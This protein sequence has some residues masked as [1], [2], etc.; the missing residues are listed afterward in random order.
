[1]DRCFINQPKEKDQLKTLLNK[2]SKASKNSGTGEKPNHQSRINNIQKFIIQNTVDRI[3]EFAVKNNVDVIVFE[4]LGRMKIPKGTFGAKRFRAKLQHWAK[5]KIQ[6]KVAE[7]A[8]SLGIRNSKVIARGTSMYAFD[9]SGK[10][11]RNKKKDIATFST[12]KTYHADLSASYNIGARYFLREIL[13]PFS[14][15]E[16]L[17]HS[18]KVPDVLV[19]TRH[20]LATLIKLHEVVS[21]ANNASVSRILVKEAPSIVTK[22]A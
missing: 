3:V 6:N 8:W 12:G 22:V 15:M 13:K 11:E 7:K 19:R 14:E 20:T 17:E 18:A 16:K 5:M 10:V 2:K 9:G 4:F 1:L 21:Y